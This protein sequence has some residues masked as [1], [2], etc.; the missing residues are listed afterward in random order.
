MEVKRVFVKKRFEFGKQC[1]LFACEPT[2]DVDIPPNPAE[3]RNYI[4]RSQCHVG[5][6]KSTQLAA[7]EAQTISRTTKSSGMYH[8]EGG[9]PKEI[10][11]RDE[12]T[13]ARFRRRVEKD[14]HWAPRL[15]NLFEVMEEGVLQNGAINIY[16]HYFDDMV[17]TEL[18]QPVS[19]RA[20]KEYIDPQR[21][22]RPVT[23][24]SVSP[25]D[26]RRIVVSYCFLDFGRRSDYSKTVYVWQVDNPNEPYMAMEPF[27][28]CVSC[29]F[30]PRDPS[31]LASALMTGQV[32]NWDLRISEKPVLYSDLLFSH[33]AYANA[34]KWLPSKSNTEFF[35]TSLDGCALWW[36]TRW[37]REP[38][39]K[40]MMDLEKPNEPSMD[41]AIGISCL[42][43]G[44]VVG[45]KFMLG[46]DN[47]IVVVGSRKA[48]TNAEKMA[49]KFAAHFGPV[50]A[51][52]RN[53]LN[54]SI[55][56][57]TGD[58]T[59]KIWAEDTREGNLV[60][61]LYMH[62]NPTSGCWDKIR[63]SVFYV[64]TDA[65]TLVA[66]DLL[67]K[68]QKPIFKLQLCD[69]K[70]TALAPY[71]EGTFMA[72]GNY[73]GT[74][75][76]VES[77]EFLERFD[78][79][80][81]AA[82]SEYLE[83]CSKLTKAVDVRLRE[84]KLMQKLTTEE[85]VALPAKGKGKKK[86][87]HMEK[88]NNKDKSNDKDK[89]KQQRKNSKKKVKNDVM[90]QFTE[91]E[92]KYYELVG[93]ELL[94]YANVSEPDLRPV[95]PLM[96][97]LKKQDRKAKKAAV[98]TEK[99]PKKKASRRPSEVSIMRRKS[100]LSRLRLYQKSSTATATLSADPVVPAIVPSVSTDTERPRKKK[101]QSIKFRLPVPC[102][103]EICKPK[104]CCF[105]RKR[106]SSGK[107]KAKK[108]ETG[109][110]SLT[111]PMLMDE[112]MVTASMKLLRG[113]SLKALIRWKMLDLPAELMQ[114]VERARR[115]I[116]ELAP[117]GTVCW[118]RRMAKKVEEE[119]R[120]TTK[121][122]CGLVVSLL[123]L[124]P[125]Y[126]L[127]Y[128]GPGQVVAEIMAR[129]MAFGKV[130]GF[131]ERQA[132]DTDRLRKSQVDFEGDREDEEEESSV[133]EED[134]SEEQLPVKERRKTRV[135]VDPCGPWKGKSISEEFSAM[136]GVPMPKSIDEEV[137]EG[138][139]FMKE[140]KA[141]QA[142][143]YPRISE[144]HTIE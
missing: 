136:I 107:K 9:W 84:I 67:Q 123:F 116:R 5:P 66:W 119:K 110:P 13:T 81:R 121:F 69:S 21:P 40:V 111:S 104:V 19:L 1:L 87:K 38:V 32:C 101:K 77:T 137:E 135:S 95:G 55:F 78:R 120:V 74:S 72:V 36:D 47:G 100:L 143:I 43:F 97:G 56:M 93:Q 12:E 105:R 114:E 4:T 61:T 82:L 16:Q 141:I 79:K 30:N 53:V 31:V 128:A 29:E 3:M 34:V 126:I 133:S 25:D 49:V 73:N 83:R 28:P 54:P 113:K 92:N 39:E 41:R 45:T 86:A 15:H 108:L 6:Q 24:I 70:I 138:K 124:S 71:E 76:L 129:P 51:V 42:N 125:A 48:K 11:P 68:L 139:A 94:Q 132:S 57:S 75:Y 118:K 2:L 17:P 26:G 62:D 90:I 10:N 37:L 8:F 7:H 88:D 46:M 33:R 103:K 112:P 91:A 23:D 50:F 109:T 27:C 134:S 106:G 59:V 80:D 14:D 127:F 144:F 115:E 64:T 85:E 102:K 96:I 44:P 60:S 35:S 140:M 63:N 52:D 22:R 98:T 122:V 130:S 117:S 131:G 89:D 142:R 20:V 65:G 99:E 18:V 58:W